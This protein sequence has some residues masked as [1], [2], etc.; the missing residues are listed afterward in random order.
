VRLC[1]KCRKRWIPANREI[2][3]W[4]SSKC[5]IAAYFSTDAGKEKHK[6][7]M[8]EHRKSAGYKLN[9]QTRGRKGGRSNAAV[10][11]G[12]DLVVLV[13]QRRKALPGF[14][15]KHQQRHR[16]KGKGSADN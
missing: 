2:D 14:D 3:K 4:C 10:Q 8:R 11:K 5:R 12:K 16:K 6:K 9:H 7:T 1:Q 13:S 15:Q